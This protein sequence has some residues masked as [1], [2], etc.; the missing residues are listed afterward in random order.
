MK[1]VLISSL[2][3]LF[4]TVSSL[5]VLVH[6]MDFHVVSNTVN[7][8]SAA[9]I[10]VKVNTTAKFYGKMYYDDTVYGVPAPV[11]Y[12]YQ[13]NIPYMPFKKPSNIGG[14]F[15]YMTFSYVSSAG[16][17][18]T[19]EWQA[20]RDWWDAGVDTEYATVN[21]TAESFKSSGRYTM[22]DGDNSVPTVNDYKTVYTIY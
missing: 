5:P 16:L 12:Q 18:K 22:G 3:C 13:M 7:G 2:L 17:T 4:L 21:A 11:Q 6:A 10:N 15:S 1:K 14:T 19:S 9:S 8:S 20:T